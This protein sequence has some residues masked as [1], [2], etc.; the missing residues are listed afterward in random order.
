MSADWNYRLARTPYLVV[1]RL[2]IEAMPQEW[3]DRLEALLLE[4]DAAGLET[5]AYYVFRNLSMVDASDDPFLFGVKDVGRWDHPHYVFGGRSFSGDPWAN[6][7]H[8]DVQK[9]CPAFKPVE[10]PKFDP[11]KPFGGDGSVPF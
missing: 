5:P 7:R 10:Q 8:G 6:Y 2:A 9:L 3:Q 4:A 11:S 1:P